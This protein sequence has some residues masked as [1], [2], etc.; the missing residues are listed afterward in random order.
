MGD[1]GHAGPST[2]TSTQRQGVGGTLRRIGISTVALATALVFAVPAAA[3]DEAPWPMFDADAQGS[4]QAAVSGPSDPGL[5][6]HLDLEQVETTDAPEG[7]SLE[8]GQRMQIAG[9]GTMITRAENNDPQYDRSSFARELIGIDTDDGTV[10]WQ[11]DNISPNVSTRMCRPGIDDQDRVWA[12]TR[13][14]DCGYVVAAYETA[15]GNEVTGTQIAADDQ[16]CRE[17]VLI[18]GADQHL[19]FADGSPEGLRIFDISGSGATE[20]TSGIEVDN[21]DGLSNHGDT[22]AWGVF[23]DATFITA[24]D[25]DDA[26]DERIDL[27]EISLS[28][29]S[30]VSQVEAPTASGVAS[31]DFSTVILALD[32]STDTL[33]AS[34]RSGAGSSPG[35]IIAGLDTSDALSTTW[36][37]TDLER[38]P[39]DLTLGDGT[40][41]FQE[42]ARTTAPGATLQGLSIANG[43][44]TI[45]GLGA[46]TRPVTNPDGSGYTSWRTS[47]MTRDRLITGFSAQ[48]DVQWT[49]PPGRIAGQ[50]GLES[51]E[52]LNMSGFASLDMASIGPDGTLYVTGGRTGDGILAI[53]D[54][55]GLAQAEAPFPDVDPDSVHAPNI[56]EMAARGITTGDADGNYNPGGNVTR[57]QFATFL[58]RALEL[59]PV[60]E[61]P[62]DDVDPDNVHAP[63][64]NA[65]A[66]AEITT[67]VTP[68][69]FDPN[70]QITRDQVASLLARAFELDEIADG[71]FTDVDPGSVHAGNINAVAQAGI[72]TGVTDTTFNPDGTVTRAQM[73]SLLIRALDSAE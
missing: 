63:N 61:G 21:A 46:G 10:T 67:G 15:S 13:D 52:D 18:G 64:I 43:D 47:D 54:T 26:G 48:G 51:V 53:D 9:D 20:V 50:L 36:T 32:Q 16:R 56:A 12:E 23:T 4:G 37:H 2:T 68:T 5:K 62:F 29:G 71:P 11:I 60:S 33:I 38:E 58:V 40:V 39:R 8:D 72:T 1:R 55:G 7:Y 59:D 28:N 73:A 41:L 6:W 19:V 70:G 69:A 3:Q 49:I 42:G 24:V 57:A 45:E 22:A 17:H 44:V 31:G 35:P 65:A 30:I 27:V 14:D 34:M 66:E 25:I